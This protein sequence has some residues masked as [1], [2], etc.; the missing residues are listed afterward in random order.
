VTVSHPPCCKLPLLSA[1]TAVTFPALEHDRPYTGT[2]LYCL[3]TEAQVCEQLTQL[4]PEQQLNPR[5]VDRKSKFQR[6][7]R[8]HGRR[9]AWARG[10]GHLPPLEMHKRV[11][12]TATNCTL[13]YLNRQ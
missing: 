3:V 6:S 12:V 7:T 4:C 9:Q 1:R 5:P 11:V 10:G 2:N 13:E 8:C